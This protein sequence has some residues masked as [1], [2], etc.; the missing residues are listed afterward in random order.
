MKRRWL[1]G[2]VMIAAAIAFVGARAFAHGPGMWKQHLEKKLESLL[3]EANATPEQRNAVRA[4]I[5]HVIATAEE[6]HQGQPAMM[7]EAAKLFEADRLDANA[8]AQHRKQHEAAEQKIGDAVVQALSDIHDTLTPSQ[9]RV[10][11]DAIRSHRDERGMHAEFFKRM[12]TAKIDDALDAANVQGAARRAAYDAR[13]RVFAAIEQVQR[14]HV[15][16]LDQ[17]IAIFTADKIDSNAV[18]QLRAKHQAETKQTGDAIVAAIT[19]LHDALDAGQRKALVE[20]ARSHRPR[21]A[22]HHGG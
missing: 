9:R 21:W 11:A 3:D 5:D 6:T 12:I 13:D 10:V 19:E 18:A 7:D 20:Y 15:A 22:G 17:A 2:L 1:M 8:I 4:A 16:D 14:Q